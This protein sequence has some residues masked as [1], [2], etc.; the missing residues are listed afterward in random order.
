MSRK[1]IASKPSGPIVSGKK[2]SSP[3]GAAL[4]RGRKTAGHS[5]ISQHGG[6]G[7]IGPKMG[8][9][10]NQTGAKLVRNS[11]AP[12]V[13]AS[14]PQAQ[15]QQQHS[16]NGPLSKAFSGPDRGIAL[17]NKGAQHAGRPWRPHS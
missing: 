16:L 13:A 4:V 17:K 1:G 5:G 2:S 7:H 15:T 14:R 8:S 12:A 10:Q 9:H 6:L 11:K 3:T